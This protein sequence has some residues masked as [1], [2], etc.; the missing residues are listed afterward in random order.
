MDSM[1][2]LAAQPATDPRA[3]RYLAT[4]L[5]ALAVMSERVDG[6]KSAY[7]SLSARLDRVESSVGARLDRVDLRLD[8]QEASTGMQL[9]GMGMFPT[10]S[11]SFSLPPFR[12][13]PLTVSVRFIAP[14]VCAIISTSDVR[15]V[16]SLTVLH[17]TRFCF[18]QRCLV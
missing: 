8:R 12:P 4:R 1:D 17:N 15:C 13:N 14:C 5:E 10:A 7:Q 11:G 3:D 2:R 9:S 18:S 16:V 6:L